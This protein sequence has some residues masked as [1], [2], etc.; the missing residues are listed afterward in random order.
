VRQYLTGCIEQIKL[1]LHLLHGCVEKL[2]GRRKSCKVGGRPICIKETAARV[3]HRDAVVL[4]FQDGAQFLLY[5]MGP[6]PKGDRFSTLGA[7][8]CG[9]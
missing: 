6:L 2:L 9:E 1:A 8:S 7:G 3:L 5:G 4:R